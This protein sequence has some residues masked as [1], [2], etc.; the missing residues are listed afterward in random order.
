MEYILIGASL[1]KTSLDDQLR[2][3]HGNVESWPSL[4]QDSNQACYQGLGILNHV[5]YN[6]IDTLLKVLNMV[7]SKGMQGK[8]GVS[9]AGSLDG[10][11]QAKA[12]LA[13][14]LA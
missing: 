14:L 13:R 12:P 11:A 6:P 4:G 8:Y 9:P 7:C 10:M 5:A 2:L 1:M 3:V